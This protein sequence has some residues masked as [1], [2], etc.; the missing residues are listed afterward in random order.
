MLKKVHKF[1]LNVEL[2]SG[3]HITGSDDTFDIGGADAQVIK[4]PLNG[5]PYIPGSTLKGKIRSLLDYKY[6]EIITAKNGT[7]DVVISEKNQLCLCLFEPNDQYDPKITRGIFRDLTLTEESKDELKNILGDGVYTEI[8]AENKINRYE[9]KA[10][11]PRFIERV[12]AGVKFTGEIDVLEFDGDNYE[13]LKQYLI[14]GLQA[15]ELN[16]IGSSGSRGYGQV[17]VEYI[18]K[19]A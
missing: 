2:I 14:E 7:K 3:M 13:K 8:K 5:E 18:E 10:E 19:D 9:G 12:P 17:K 15:L 1:V 11:S 16:F 6:G 4:N